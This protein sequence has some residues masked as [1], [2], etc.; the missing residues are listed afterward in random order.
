MATP[1]EK[2]A[3]SLEVFKKLQDSSVL[4]IRSSDL[5]RVHRE[6]LLKNGFIEEVMKGWYIPAW[7]HERVGESTAWYASYWAFCSAYLSTRFKSE[8][9]LSPEQSLA[10]HS[11]N[12]Q[13]PKQLLVRSPRAR[14]KITNLP[15]NTSLFDVKSALPKIEHLQIQDGLRIFSLASALVSCSPMYFKQHPIEIRTAL[16]LIKSPSDILR[17]LLDG[18]HSTIAGRLIGAFRNIGRDRIADDILR[19]MR[20]ADYTIQETDPFEE[21]LALLDLE[22]NDSAI[23]M[24]LKLMWQ[25]M[26]IDI[27]GRFPDPVLM[28]DSEAYL[29]TVDELYTTD[30][31]H[32]LS[33]EGYKVNLDLIERVRTG[34]WNPESFAEDKQQRDAM[35]ARG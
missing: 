27:I 23:T 12:T 5:T 24:R 19:T 17:I 22:K 6:R 33:I 7:P 8:W 28:N 29:K 10:I 26:R 20:A 31:Y 2:L 3:T 9:C 13:V 34:E 18:G 30:A 35:A 4:A 14:N 16:A 21:K 25:K 11:G 32:S 1:S 15:H